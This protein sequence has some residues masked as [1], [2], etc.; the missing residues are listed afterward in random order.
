[1]GKTVELSSGIAGTDRVIENPPD[2]VADGQA[3][4]VAKASSK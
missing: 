1:L 3:V 2:G 4:H